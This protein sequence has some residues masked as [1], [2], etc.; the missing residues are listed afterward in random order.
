M[1]KTEK[2]LAKAFRDYVL[3]KNATEVYPQMGLAGEWELDTRVGKVSVTLFETWI[4]IRCKDV[5]RAKT[6]IP[7]NISSGIDMNPF[8]GK[9]NIQGLNRKE[10][11]CI[12][13]FRMTLF[14]TFKV[15]IESVL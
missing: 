5:E 12:A 4:A 11:A 9:W 3:S 13:D 8:S 6:I 10:F 15:R 1:I 7:H 14:E 2:Q